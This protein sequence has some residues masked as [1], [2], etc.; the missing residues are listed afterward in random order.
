MFF[1]KKKPFDIVNAH[2]YSMIIFGNKHAL[3]F[4]PMP[5]F[6]EAN[7]PMEMRLLVRRV[8][9]Y[10]GLTGQ[11]DLMWKHFSSLLGEAYFEEV[12]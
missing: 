1:L 4:L 10:S 8:V 5:A 12:H 6:F 9:V 3:G 2:S 11:L 7:L